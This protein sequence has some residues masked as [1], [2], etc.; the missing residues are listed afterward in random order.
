MWPVVISEMKRAR[1]GLIQSCSAARVKLPAASDRKICSASSTDAASSNPFSN[2]RQRSA[3]EGRAPPLAARSI[4]EAAR[5]P[6]RK[7]SISGRGDVKRSPA[8]SHYCYST[9]WR[10]SQLSIQTN[11]ADHALSSPPESL[12]Q[13]THLMGGIHA[14]AG[15]H[16]TRTA[17]S[18]TRSLEMMRSGGRA[19][20]KYGLPLPSTKGRK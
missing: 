14:Q 9:T 8:S 20:A 12:K 19:P 3:H 11:G 17:S 6:R 15:T 7:S 13:K 10:L 2:R 5:C 16:V 4:G 1:R 18:P